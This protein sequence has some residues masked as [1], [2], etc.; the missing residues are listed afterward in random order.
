MNSSVADIIERVRVH[1]FSC[2]A[3]TLTADHKKFMSCLPVMAY[4]RNETKRD[5]SWHASPIVVSKIYPA[6]SIMNLFDDI[7]SSWKKS[8]VVHPSPHPCE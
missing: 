3:T 4:T 8:A 1:I 2:R 6:T 7:L 5:R